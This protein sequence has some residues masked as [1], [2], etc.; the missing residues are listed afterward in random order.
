M[1]DSSSSFQARVSALQHL[2]A[3]RNALAISL[4]PLAWTF[5]MIAG[6]RREQYLRRRNTLPRP[7]VPVVVVGNITVGGTGKTPLVIWLAELLKANG[8]RPGI[9]SLGYG[10]RADHWPRIVT[11]LSDPHQVGDEPVLIASRSHCPTAVAPDRFEAARALLEEYDCDVLIADDGLQHYG[12]VRDMEIAVIDGDKGL[13]NRWCLPAGP[14][15]EPPSRLRDV[16]LVIVHDRRGYTHL[17]DMRPGVARKNP[18]VRASARYRMTLEAG[19]LVNLAD[20]N[21]R[22][23]L[24]ALRGCQV[25]ALAAIGNPARFFDTLKAGGLVLQTHVFRDHHPFTARDL[26]FGDAQALVMTEKDAVKCRAFAQAH[27]WYLP[28]AALPDA[29]FARAVLTR[30]RV[31]AAASPKQRSEPLETNRYG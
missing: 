26:D 4:L 28:V 22:Q 7:P 3:T 13:G 25:H 12:L 17:G 6:L 9:I 2:W 30:L 27:Y 10:G 5:R 8:Y 15:R 29:H 19:Q 20:A 23:P 21:L 31:L 16:D 14:L 1:R 24:E 18:G 11:A